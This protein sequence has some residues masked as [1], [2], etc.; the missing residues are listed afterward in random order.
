MVITRSMA[1]KKIAPKKKQIVKACLATEDK[2]E[3]CMCKCKCKDGYQLTEEDIETLMIIGDQTMLL[4]S[5]LMSKLMA[6]K[7][8]T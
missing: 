5:R 6:Y 8:D 3:Q 1:A 2:I 4:G 7:K